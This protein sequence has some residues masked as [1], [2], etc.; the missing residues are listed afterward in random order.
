MSNGRLRLELSDAGSRFRVGGMKGR[1]SGVDGEV[2]LQNSHGLP[3]LE[4]AHGAQR[5]GMS[6]HRSQHK[7]GGEVA[8]MEVPVDG[9]HCTRKLLHCRWTRH[10]MNAK[11]ISV[12]R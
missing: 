8:R 1:T 12:T 7:I 5:G 2:Y 6:A 10:L 4:R 3:D 9:V 11:V